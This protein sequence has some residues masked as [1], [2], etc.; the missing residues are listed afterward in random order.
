MYKDL[1]HLIREEFICPNNT[2]KIIKKLYRT[3]NLGLEFKQ[4]DKV[5]NYATAEN[6]KTFF[7]ED[8]PEKGIGFKKTLD[9][10]QKKISK[11][12]T[13][14]GSKNFMA[15]PD[16]GNAI[17]SVAGS[18][19]STF[20]NQN[21]INSK[22]CAPAASS[23][24]A[25]VISWMRSLIGYE[26][27]DNPKDI[28]DIGG[29]VVTGGVLAN[30]TAMLLARENTF[31]NTKGRGITYDPSKVKV[32]IPNG[33]E[34]YSI[35]AS[36]GWIGIGEEN[37]VRIN[38]KNYRFCL[39]DLE[40]KIE[41]YQKQHT[42]M[43]VVAY[44]G[45]SR[46]MTIDDFQSIHKIT[47]KHKIWFHVDACHGFQYIFS[48]MLKKKLGGLELADS[49]TID[50]HK[51]MFLPYNLSMVLTKSSQVF[52]AVSGSSD[53]IMREEN[54]FGQ[55]TPFLGSKAFWSLKLWFLIKS[56]GVENIGKLIE[57]RHQLAKKLA[58]KLNN[59]DEF[60]VLNKDTNINSV[61]FMYIP[62]WLRFVTQP[63]EYQIEAINQLNAKI[64][65]T[66]FR[67]GSFYIHTFVISDDSID[68]WT[69]GAMLQALRYMCGNPITQFSDIEKMLVRVRKLGELFENDYKSIDKIILR[70]SS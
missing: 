42:I 14:F 68:S 27:K 67:E 58:N 53:L 41:E 16:A 66:M 57:Q 3:I 26:I 9:I 2:E 36:L 24:E 19:L 38:T 40:K 32:F 49:I 4:R 34:H 11:Y 54:A 70:E 23:I 6:L 35:R 25:T 37:V 18:I 50:P 65:D 55:M 44:A 15:F 29:I 60:Y 48:P 51:V 7:Y 46:T 22:H 28:F 5:V 21:L 39:Y 45:D 17:S 61:V 10:F 59:T 12:S 56:L 63:S 20:L 31:P 13:N 8:V 43:A 47:S 62:S 33:I 64:Q 1:D 30:A 69:K 52:R